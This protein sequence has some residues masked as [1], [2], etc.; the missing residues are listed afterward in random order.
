MPVTHQIIAH[1]AIATT[2]ARAETLLTDDGYT[3]EPYMDKPGI[4]AVTRSENDTRPLRKG[5][6]LW[7]D[8]DVC[9]Q[10]C[11]CEGFRFRGTCKHLI[12]TSKALAE[13]AR[14]MAPML[15]VATPKIETAWPP[16][17]RAIETAFPARKRLVDMSSA[18][19][20]A[21][22]LADFG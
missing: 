3:I 2:V 11:T 6:T 18:E 19:K 10:D 17:D 1:K 15:S 22:M 20:R 9:H 5:E 14:L 4:Y 13:A 8:V 12:A 16:A 21:Q 7:N